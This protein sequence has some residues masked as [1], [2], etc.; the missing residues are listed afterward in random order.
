MKFLAVLLLAC[1]VLLS[2]FPGMV[3]PAEMPVKDPCAAEMQD[4][5]ACHEHP[6]PDSKKDC[7]KEGCNVMLSCSICGYLVVEPL[8]FNPVILTYAQKSVSFYKMGA[9]SGYH[10]A[11]WK[12]PKSC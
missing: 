1:I 10:A 7:G 6:K 3:K 8:I 12:P 4:K 9:L 11:D 2:A 5:D